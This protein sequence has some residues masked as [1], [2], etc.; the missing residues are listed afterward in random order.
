MRAPERKLTGP[1]TLLVVCRTKGLSNSRE[2]LA[3]GRPAHPHRRQEAGGEGKGANSAP[4]T[5][6]PTK[7][8]TGF[9]FL[10]KDFLRFWMVDIHREGRG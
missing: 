1:I 5:A 9:Q 3:G 10:T 8:Q 7:W 6:P 2:E 4:E